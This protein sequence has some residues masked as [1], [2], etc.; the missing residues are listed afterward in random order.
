MKLD[1]SHNNAGEYFHRGNLLFSSYTEPFNC[2]SMKLCRYHPR[3]HLF[4][5]QLNQCKSLQLNHFKQA[6]QIIPKALVDYYVLQSQKG[7]TES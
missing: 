5:L 6:A 7:E 2:C 1:C 4:L 3:F